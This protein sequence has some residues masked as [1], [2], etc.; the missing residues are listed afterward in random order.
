[1]PARAE[2]RSV[3]WPVDDLA[4]AGFMKAFYANM[5]RESPAAAL[6]SAKLAMIHGAAPAAH[7]HPYFC[8]PLRVE[9]SYLELGLAALWTLYRRRS[10][11]RQQISLSSPK[12][13]PIA[14]ALLCLTQYAAAD[15]ILT[16]RTPFE[17]MVQARFRYAWT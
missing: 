6:R 10:G 13:R 16:H 15:G 9:R 3:F 1:M 14:V 4:T 7:R 17:I 12:N 8:Q 5:V 11:S 2:S